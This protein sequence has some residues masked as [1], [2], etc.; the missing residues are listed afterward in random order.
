[1]CR[2]NSYCDGIYLDIVPYANTSN[3]MSLSTLIWCENGVN[4]TTLI[5]IISFIFKH[6]ANLTYR[7]LF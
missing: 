4:N 1:M 7:L 5:R 2:N 3:F 6:E